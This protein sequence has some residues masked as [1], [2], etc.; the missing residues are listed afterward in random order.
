MKKFVSA[1]LVTVFLLAMFPAQAEESIDLSCLTTPQII[2]LYFNV[3]S[4]LKIREFSSMTDEKANIGDSEILFRKVPWES[5]PEEFSSLADLP[6]YKSSSASKSYSWERRGTDVGSSLYSLSDA[7]IYVFCHPDKFSVVGIPVESV[8]AYFIY[9]IDNNGMPIKDDTSARLYKAEYSFD[10]IDMAATYEIL[11]Q[12]MEG[13]YG[14]GEEYEHVQSVWNLTGNDYKEYNIW[15]VWYGA[16]NTGVYLKMEYH[17]DSV[18]GTIEFENL[19]L[20]YGKSNS[21]VMLSELETAF[22]KEELENM[23]SID[24]TDGL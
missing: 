11:E 12:K 20:V 23:I 18:D 19:V 2:D 16:N 22:A 10:P 14:C 7:G 3:L 9:D 24:D 8:Y 1:F 21:L 6:S 5:T 13:L 17:V 15:H 4:E